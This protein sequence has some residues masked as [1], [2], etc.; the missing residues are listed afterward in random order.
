MDDEKTTSTGIDGLAVQIS[1][2][3]QPPQRAK[4]KDNANKTAVGGLS[5]R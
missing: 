3:I 4:G 1:W 5:G 2:R